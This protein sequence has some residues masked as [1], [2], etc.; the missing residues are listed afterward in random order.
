MFFTRVTAP[1]GRKLIAFVPRTSGEMLKGLGGR[2]WMSVEAGMLFDFGKVQETRRMTTDPMLFDLDMVW[3]D[4]KKS[5]LRVDRGV[6]LHVHP[7]G[8]AQFVLELVSGAADVYG[9]SI[10]SRLSWER[11]RK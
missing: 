11:P 5:V 6:P 3:M 9:I 4:S 7:V 10:G 8:T 1:N 2:S